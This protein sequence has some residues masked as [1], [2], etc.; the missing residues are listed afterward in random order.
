MEQNT[1]W[2]FEDRT[3]PQTH[4]EAMPWV[5][6]IFSFCKVIQ[7][8]SASERAREAP[9]HFETGYLFQYIILSMNKHPQCRCARTNN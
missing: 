3:A 6:F 8:K 7:E 2:L 4:S 9:L 5:S 1:A